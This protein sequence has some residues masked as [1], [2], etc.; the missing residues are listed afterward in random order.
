M[1]SKSNRTGKELLLII[2][3]WL[4][5]TYRLKFV[6][7]WLGDPWP[8][9]IFSV[10]KKIC[11]RVTL[12]LWDVRVWEGDIYTGMSDTIFFWEVE[13]ISLNGRK[14]WCLLEKGVKTKSAV[15]WMMRK[16]K[17]WISETILNLIKFFLMTYKNA[18]IKTLL[19]FIGKDSGKR[20]CWSRYMSIWM[21]LIAPSV[22]LEDR[23]KSPNVL[24]TSFTD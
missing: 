24:K 4:K 19:E 14:F 10:G 16:K 11:G 23:L 6:L 22:H 20:F 2:W 5:T 15:L 17:Y 21:L 8:I 12:W 18:S 13:L 9:Y 7:A 3:T 1:S